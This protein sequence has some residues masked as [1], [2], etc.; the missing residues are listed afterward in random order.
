MYAKLRTE[1]FGGPLAQTFG[2]QI[3]E[4]RK[5]T[6]RSLRD[7]AAAIGR[8]PSYLNDIEHGRRVPSSDV[9]TELAEALHLDRDVLLAAA[10][11]VGDGAEEYMRATPNAGVLLRKVS[12]AGLSNEDLARL[13]GDAE[14]LIKNREAGN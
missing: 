11:R 5:G 1:Y 14:K 2:E 8:S 12:N 7:L 3:A 6:G 4:A 13:I 9:V 10:G